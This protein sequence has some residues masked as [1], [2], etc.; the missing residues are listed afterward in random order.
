VGGYVEL[1]RRAKEVGLDVRAVIL[2]GLEPSKEL[3]AMVPRGREGGEGGEGGREGV[4]AGVHSGRGRERERRE[5]SRDKRR[6]RER[7]RDM[8]GRE[9]G[10]GPPRPHHPSL[11]SRSLLSRIQNMPSSPKSPLPASTRLVFLLASRERLCVPRGSCLCVSRERL[12]VSRE[13]LCVSRERLCVS[14]ERLCV[15]RPVSTCACRVP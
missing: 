1:V 9:G 2:R 15:S 3:A 11:D 8:A 12:C 14:R 10:A 4:G 13:R 5:I 6:E 7:D